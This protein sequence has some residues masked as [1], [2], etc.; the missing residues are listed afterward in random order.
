M[1]EGLT[2]ADSCARRCSSFALSAAAAASA[3]AEACM[4]L[5]VWASL[6]I[7]RPISAICKGL[8]VSGMKAPIPHPYTCPLTDNARS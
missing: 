2:S 6:A 3:S 1:T 7:F 5:A 8:T 4:P